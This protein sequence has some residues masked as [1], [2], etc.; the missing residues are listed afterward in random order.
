VFGEN[1]DDGIE[2]GGATVIENYIFDNSD[3][4]LVSGPDGNGFANNVLYLNR[5]GMVGDQV[6][7][8]PPLHPNICHDTPVLTGGRR[9]RRRPVPCSAIFQAA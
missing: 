1:G 8:T 9:M 3:Y 2:A 6:L 5:A 4:G 7:G